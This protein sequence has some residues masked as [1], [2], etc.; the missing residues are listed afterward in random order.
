MTIDFAGW[1]E[2]QLALNPANL[3]GPLFEAAR[4]LNQLVVGKDVQLASIDSPPVPFQGSRQRPKHGS[5][6]IPIPITIRT[7][8]FDYFSWGSLRFGRQSVQSGPRFPADGA[9]AG[10]QSPNLHRPLL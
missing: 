9:G 1:L 8:A 6:G 2:P 4:E 5:T 7:L 3:R 10:Q